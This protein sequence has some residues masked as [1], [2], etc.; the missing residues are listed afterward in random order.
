MGG[1]LFA[2]LLFA[3]LAASAAGQ[4]A[5]SDR[6]ALVA[7]FEA[8][9][10]D[11]WSDGTNWLSAEPLEAW[12]GVTTDRDGRVTLLSLH[13]NG[14][15]GR[16]PPELARLTE[17]TGLFLSR[18]ALSGEIPPEVGSLAKLTTLFLS[19][20][21]LSGDIPP[22]LGT[23][24]NL[25]EIDL[26]HNAL[27]GEVPSIWRSLRKL[28][29]LRLSG[30]RLTGEIPPDLGNSTSLM[31]LNLSDNALTGGVPAA[32]GSLSKLAWLNLSG[33]AL[34][35]GIASELT[36]LTRLIALDLSGN[37]LTGSIPAGVARLAD[38]WQLKLHST[39]LVGPIPDGLGDLPNLELLELAFNERLTGSVPS[40]LREASLTRLDLTGTP[41]CVPPA[42]AA[43]QAWLG[44]MEDFRS[45]GLTCGEPVPALSTV[46]LAVFYTPAAS[47]RAGGKAAIEA[48]IDLMVAETNQAY[49]ASGVDLRVVL[50]VRSETP[51]EEADSSIDLRRLMNPSDGYLDAVH[52]IRDRVG[53]DLVHLIVGADDYDAGG[54]AQ[55]VSAFGLSRYG[56]GGSTLA[57]EIGHNMGLN[58]ERYEQCQAHCANWPYRFAYG[59]VNRRGFDPDAPSSAR[60]VT[61]M[62][63]H[64]QC[65]DADVVCR[66]LLRFSNSS[67]T[68]QGNP[69]GMP[70]EETSFDVGGPADAVRVLNTMRHSVASLRD[71]ASGNRPTGIGETLPSEETAAAEAIPVQPL[72][73]PQVG[74]LFA[75]VAPTAPAVALPDDPTTL[76]RREVSVD[77]ER[78]AGPS[79]AAWAGLPAT[80]VMNLFDDVVQTGSVARRAPTFSGGYALSGGLAGVESGT[81][82]LVV[83]GTVVAGSIRTPEATYRIRPAG[84]GRQVIIQ[85]DPARFARDGVSARRPRGQPR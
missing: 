68:Y 35:G 37:D 34:S 70:G 5:A 69:L 65:R 75:M 60:W 21:R 30:N 79:K 78:L 4:P 1:R 80:L 61:I 81:M 64:D 53:A 28:V 41:V 67:R 82:T 31:E 72:P 27:T 38:L 6:A 36:G 45:P 19:A 16:I 2:G 47:S 40:R 74:G 58:H 83:N 71:S 46:D 66:E 22:A 12:H 51:Y 15:R 85:M 59:Y 50:A 33:N 23:L 25:R 20:N 8:T 49:E 73:S 48:V 3:G 10:G 43:F 7:L 14:L 84:A 9:S 42:D 32:L 39:L 56:S 62:A 13:D 29:R 55:Q 18:N 76:R 44:T 54:I 77:L 24:T 52:A 26:S 57:H 11:D 17:L 63:Y